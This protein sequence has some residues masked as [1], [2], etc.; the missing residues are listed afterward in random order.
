MTDS[1]T[2]SFYTNATQLV[3]KPSGGYNGTGDGVGVKRNG[4]DCSTVRAA[5]CS[6]S[7]R[8]SCVAGLKKML[9]A[10]SLCV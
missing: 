6:C 8:W 7:T 2:L 3:V 4:T 1:L 5:C 10:K 9:P